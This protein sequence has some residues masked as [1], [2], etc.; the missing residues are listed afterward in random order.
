MTDLPVKLNLGCGRD[1]RKGYVNVDR[2]PPVDLIF[3]LD[4]LPWPF[5]SDSVDEI[6]MSH[7]LEHLKEPKLALRECH[8]ILKPGGLLEIR[9]PHRKYRGAYCLGHRTY[10][11]EHSLGGFTGKGSERSCD[12]EKLFE[13]V[14]VHVHHDWG[15]LPPLRPWHLNRY[16]GR[17]EWERLPLGSVAEVHYL[18]EAVK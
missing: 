6:Y 2:R 12:S 13:E 1:L 3:D 5:A 4:S 11:D 9:V 15:F 18:L 16:V 14:D 17:W 10:F 7:I 8:R